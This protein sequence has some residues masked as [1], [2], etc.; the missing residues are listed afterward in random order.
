MKFGKNLKEL[1][2]NYFG[3]Y[4]IGMDRYQP[5]FEGIDRWYSN[6]RNCYLKELRSRPSI[7][8]TKYSDHSDVIYE[9]K[10]P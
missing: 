10:F 3:G 9:S 5:G 8:K 6:C 2:K 4:R 7:L 1:I